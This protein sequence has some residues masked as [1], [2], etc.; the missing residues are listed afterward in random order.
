LHC[1]PHLPVGCIATKS[2]PLLA[3]YS[4][5]EI[6]ITGLGG[7]AALPHL[8]TDPIVAACA[9]VSGLQTIVARNLD[10]TQGAVLSVC[11]IQGGDAANVIPDHVN[12]AGTVRMFEPEV[13]E[14]LKR[15]IEELTQNVVAGFGCRAETTFT[16]AYPS[17]MNDP[18]ATAFALSVAESIA[19]PN[20]VHR[21][22]TPVLA[23]ED[24]AFYGREV[25]S[26]F[27]LIG[28]IPEGRESHPGL[29][30]PQFDFTDAALETGI[31][32]MCGYVLSPLAA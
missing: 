24:F 11:R 26:C 23:S 25:P 4:D 16:P 32:M 29:H 14:M 19:G 9:L 10:P 7:H 18:A 12:L 15:R 20:R 5:F 13:F 17:V 21:M 2:G 22:A 3:G 28:V 30:S 6:T 1:T 31:K 8:A 27:S